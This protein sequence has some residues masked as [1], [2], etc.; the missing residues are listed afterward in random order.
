MLLMIMCGA[1][2]AL[3]KDEQIE[4]AVLELV[5]NGATRGDTFVLLRGDDVL[6]P[7]RHL[8]MAGLVRLQAAAE[9]H[10]G[11]AYV[12]L[13]G[14]GLPFRYDPST[15]SLEVTAPPSALARASLDLSAP[16][17]AGL[18][19]DYT[20]S[21]FLN[22]APRLIDGRSFQTFGETGFS[23][24][25][26][27]MQTSANYDDHGV[28]RLLSTATYDDTAQLR[29][30]SLGDTFLSAGP[31]GGAVT[32]G[33]VAL[34]RNYE[35]DPY[36]V[37]IPRLGYTGSTLSPSTVDVYVNGAL[38]RRVPVAPGEF[39]LTN[40]TPI[41][42]AGTTRYVIR[43]AH[44]QE[45]QLE[46]AYYSSSGVLAQGLSEYAYG[47]GLVRQDFGTESFN[48][49]KP[50]VLGRHRF[51]VTDQLTPGVHLEFDGSLVNGGSNVTFA[52]SFGELELQ[53]AGSA[54]TSGAR[55]QGA[56]GL[57]GYTF[58]GARASFRVLFRS[59]SLHFATLS[60]P[61]YQYRSMLEQVTSTSLSIAS[62]A[63]L[64]SNSSL[65]LS[66]DQT[67]Q[68]RFSLA[69]N[70]QLSRDLALQV[71]GSRS[72]FKFGQWDHEAFAAL[73]WSLPFNHMAQLS[74]RTD[75]QGT[76]VTGRLSRAAPYPTGVGYQVNGTLGTQTSGAASVQGQTPFGIA[77]A[78]YTYDSGIHSTLLEASGGIVFMA[79]RPYFT[80][81]VTQSYAVLEVPGVPNVRG[82][83]NNLEVGSTDDT[84]ALFVPD[85][86]AHQANLLRINQ[87]DLPLEYHFE[88]DEVAYAPP[89]RGGAVIQY[90]VRPVRIYRGRVVRGASRHG[91]PVKYASLRIDTPQGPVQSLLGINGEFELDG[92]GQGRFTGQVSSE[93][94]DCE[95]ALELP[96]S[97]AIVQYLG[98]LQCL[99]PAASPAQGAP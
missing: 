53:A 30:A 52:G 56:A 55:Q 57:A 16:P 8:Q 99:P 77:S 61:P 22:Y 76:D 14:A 4:R 23:L 1:S 28:T 19:H 97:Q 58:R 29:T 36:L 27:Q 74:S 82:Y 39:Q 79:G 44:G 40:I 12:S 85:L 78:S 81:P 80:R 35:L 5:V 41:S 73:S 7:L 33:G 2:A 9:E 75:E 83:L 91:A 69:L 31:L 51:G 20:P 71:R 50:A 59:T 26:F 92:L 70:V 65:A 38:V 66:H 72:T 15:L 90:S 89:R 11:V 48:Y 43:D 98:T 42:G 68:A 18:R 47:I 32:I 94:G 21:L 63:S 6:V 37:K 45:Q 25:A 67:V 60:L 87:A 84:G 95:V 49:G 93:E 17:P 96:P 62:R 46:S 3:G 88:E 64:S 54:G 86:N 34:A 24:G 13:R 10:Q